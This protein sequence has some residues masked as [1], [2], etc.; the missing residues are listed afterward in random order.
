M[1]HDLCDHAGDNLKMDSTLANMSIPLA[2]DRCARSFLSLAET[3]KRPTRFADQVS[4]GMVLDEF[5]RF[6][7]W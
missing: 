4:A 1:P 7:L 3:L 5:D 6:K 2:V